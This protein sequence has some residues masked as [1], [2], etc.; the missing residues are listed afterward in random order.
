[1]TFKPGDLVR[2][3]KNR[4]FD[5]ISPD[6]KTWIPMEPGMLG[7]VIPNLRDLDTWIRLLTPNGIGDCYYDDV[8]RCDEQ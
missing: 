8:E 7:L 6:T 1:M 2:S 3:T 4:I 5:L